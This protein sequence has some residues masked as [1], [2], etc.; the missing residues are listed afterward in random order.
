MHLLS[1]EIARKQRKK[2]IQVKGTKDV[3]RLSVYR[4][5]KRVYLQLINDDTQKTLQGVRGEIYA[6][7]SQGIA[8]AFQ[9]GEK[10]GKLAVKAKIERAVF[11]RG[12][13]KFHGQ[14]KAV[15]E[16]ALKGGL[17]FSKA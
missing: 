9:A 17:K 8:M 14:I 1:R 7:G 16:G 12:G 11:D 6:K 2:R 3:P 5:N 15:H 13:Y 4:S 10:I